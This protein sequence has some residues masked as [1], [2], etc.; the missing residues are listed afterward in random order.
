MLQTRAFLSLWESLRFSD[1]K[2]TK[3]AL[4]A[5][6]YQKTTVR[7]WPPSTATPHP[8]EPSAEEW[9]GISAW[10]VRYPAEMLLWANGGVDA[11]PASV[12]DGTIKSLSKLYQ[13]DPDSPFQNLR[14]ETKQRYVYSLNDA[15]LRAHRPTVVGHQVP[16]TLA[17]NR[18]VLRNPGCRPESR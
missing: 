1:S 8:T 4:V 18:P 2:R 9:E 6:G 3:T 17:A 7:L 16:H 13:A 5:R 14:H 10:C 12:F 15:D 11:G